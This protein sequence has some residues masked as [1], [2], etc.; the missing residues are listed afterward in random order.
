MTKPKTVRAKA[1]TV[2]ERRFAI[3]QPNGKTPYWSALY[4]CRRDAIDAACQG[5]MGYS[6]Y[7]RLG[8]N[9]SR[10]TYLSR[11]GHRVVPVQVEYRQAREAEGRGK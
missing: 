3:L 1:N 7:L 11:Q 5:L 9:R 4:R 6:D 2:A 8:N 10:W